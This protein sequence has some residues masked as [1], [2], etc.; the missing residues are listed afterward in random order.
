MSSLNVIE[1]PWSS[2]GTVQSVQNQTIIKQKSSV[3][4]ANT[5]LEGSS[6]TQS[7]IQ[8]E[9]PIIKQP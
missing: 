6:S 9:L 4:L 2:S 8:H 1:C 3:Y 7:K 5:Q